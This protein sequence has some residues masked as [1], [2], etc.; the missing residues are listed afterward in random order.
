MMLENDTK[1]KFYR[2]MADTVLEFIRLSDKDGQ[3]DHFAQKVKE[4][5]SKEY[6]QCRESMV[7]GFVRSADNEEMLIIYKEISM[8][9]G[10]S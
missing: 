9:L 10:D 6:L 3:L 4:K 2:Y 8:L 1:I 5:G 7:N